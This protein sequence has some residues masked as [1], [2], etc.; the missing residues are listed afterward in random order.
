MRK[1]DG[2]SVVLTQW[3][4]YNGLVTASVLVKEIATVSG[5][6]YYDANAEGIIAAQGPQSGN[7][8]VQFF[9]GCFFHR[10][11]ILG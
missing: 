3:Y 10:L 8:S 5:A 6:I 4:S 9:T 1:E 7:S 2:E 11:V